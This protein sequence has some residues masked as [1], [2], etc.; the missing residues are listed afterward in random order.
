MSQKL[1]TSQSLSTRPRP[2][3]PHRDADG[4]VAEWQSGDELSERQ[5]F[6]FSYGGREKTEKKKK[7][8]ILS[9]RCTVGLFEVQIQHGDCMFGFQGYHLTAAHVN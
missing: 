8:K 6:F 1:A 4:G 7:K 2:P 3:L 9:A 5:I